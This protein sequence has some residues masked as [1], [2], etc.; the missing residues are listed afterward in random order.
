M[1]A[2]TQAH[3][4]HLALSACLM[5][6][7][8]KNGLAHCHLCNMQT[9]A[10]L[11]KTNAAKASVKMHKLLSHMQEGVCWKCGSVCKLGAMEMAPWMGLGYLSRSLLLW[12]LF[13]Q[14]FIP[15][16]LSPCVVVKSWCSRWH[17]A[18]VCLAGTLLGPFEK[19]WNATSA[20][21]AP[22]AICRGRS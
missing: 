20:T 5:D 14:T 2:T 7:A 9:S 11:F 12:T 22:S 18:Q 6:W 19:T 16:C 1:V 21:S 8:E 4:N 3:T 15:L 10:S 13:Y 17:N